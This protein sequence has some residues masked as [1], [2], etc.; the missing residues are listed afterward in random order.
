MV[1]H[2][3]GGTVALD[4]IGDGQDVGQD[5]FVEVGGGGVFLGFARGSAGFFGVCG[6]GG[7]SSGSGGGGR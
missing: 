3:G 4:V 5:S 7:G 2:C 1:E 6:G